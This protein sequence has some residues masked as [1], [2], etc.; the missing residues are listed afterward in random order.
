MPF[1]DKQIKARVA[2]YNRCRTNNV[3]PESGGILDQPE[4]LMRDF[5]FIDG[6]VAE[7]ARRRQEE[8]EAARRIN[9]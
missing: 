1:V 3:L 7:D 2:L 9:G 5:D 6:V 8:R 4:S